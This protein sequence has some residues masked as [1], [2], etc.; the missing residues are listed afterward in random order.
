[1]KPFGDSRVAVYCRPNHRARL[2]PTGGAAGRRSA[3]GA[4]P[5]ATREPSKKSDNNLSIAR[6][7]SRNEPHF[8]L[9]QGR[10]GYPPPCSLFLL[11]GANGA[12]SFDAANRRFL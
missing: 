12:E 5:G 8:L 11:M 2:V 4:R 7:R 6:R 9:R 1:M 3:G 10:M